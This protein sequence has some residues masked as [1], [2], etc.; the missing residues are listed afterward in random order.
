MKLIRLILV[1]IV[2][3]L[4]T[5][6]HDSY[7]QDILTS[8][9]KQEISNTNLSQENL[10]AEANALALPISEVATFP[11]EYKEK[12]E[13]CVILINYLEEVNNEYILRIT[14]E[15]AISLGISE[16]IFEDCLKDIQAANK[17]IEYCNNNNIPIHNSNI[18]AESKEYIENTINNNIKHT[19]S[20]ITTPMS[21]RIDTNSQEEGY[22]YLS[23]DG[24]NIKSIYF[25]CR[26]HIALIALSICTVN[27]FS[28]TYTDSIETNC[29]VSSR[30]QM[31]IA[32]TGSGIVAKLG[33]SVSDSNGGYAIW[34][35]S[36]DYYKRKD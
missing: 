15:E 36:S 30:L 29:F 5:A 33:F 27:A 21:G 6:C 10:I 4:I 17:A 34:S 16:S 9:A 19:P 11:D 35:G 14:K 8:V 20:T 13:A 3:L 12:R 23:T 31:P 1:L 32:A 24:R 2:P 26:S 22:G 18:I 28:V 7:D 25:D